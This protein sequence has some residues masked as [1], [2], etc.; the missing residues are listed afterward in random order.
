MDLTGVQLA[1]GTPAQG[2]RGGGQGADAGWRRAPLYVR[3]AVVNAAVLLTATMVL[4]LTPAQVP[5]PHR[6]A[7]VVAIVVGV[8]V[9]AGA[10]A[11]LV[12]F[13]FRPLSDLSSAMRAID[14][15]RPGSRLHEAGV[16]EVS[17]V[18]TTFNAM[19]ERLEKERLDSNRR[20]HLAREAERRRIGHE[21]HDEIGQRLTAVLLRLQ[22]ALEDSAPELRAE[23][24]RV[25]EL[26]RDTLDEV[27]RIAWLMRPVILDDLGITDALAAL[28]DGVSDAAGVTIS[29]RAPAVVPAL[30]PD[31][32]IVL[33]RVAQEALTN[34]LRHADASTISLELATHETTG[35]RLEVADDGRGLDALAGEG[36]GLRGMRERALSIGAE[37]TIESPPGL[38]V[39]VRLLVPGPVV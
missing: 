15:L 14:L 26:T 22:R 2:A 10:N 18:I 17:S 34:A 9:V 39:T 16:P 37:L 38:G 5:F 27:G 33:Y 3:V 35:V 29:L 28:V 36:S 7:D 21:L 13:V 19:L 25:Q 32:E 30:G 11:M 31:A 1:A 6:L 12:R 24:E 8:L 4:S 20:T 23:L